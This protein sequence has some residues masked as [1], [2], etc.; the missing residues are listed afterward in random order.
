[1]NGRLADKET[2]QCDRIIRWSIAGL[3]VANL[4]FL[5]NKI[6]IPRWIAKYRTSNQMALT[7]RALDHWKS[8][9]SEYPPTLGAMMTDQQ[10]RRARP[11][12]H[13][14]S[15]NRFEY[16]RVDPNSYFLRSFGSDGSPASTSDDHDDIVRS[17]SNLIIGGLQFQSLRQFE[18][19]AKSSIAST[20]FTTWP[21]AATD[22]LWSPDGSWLARIV[23]N[24]DKGERRL[25]IISQDRS[26]LLTSPHDRVEEFMWSPHRE[27]CL[28]FSATGSDIHGDG[29]F[30]WCP[31]M[32]ADEQNRGLINLLPTFATNESKSGGSATIAGDTNLVAKFATNQN[33]NK[34]LR[35]IIA[36]LQPTERSLGGIDTLNLL[37]QTEK[38]PLF[39]IL[40]VPEVDFFSDNRSKKFLSAKNLW[41]CRFQSGNCTHI[42]KNRRLLDSLRVEFKLA[43]DPSTTFRGRPT[44]AQVVWNQLPVRGPAQKLLERWLA[45]AAN[46]AVGALQAYVMFYTV[47]LQD[48]VGTSSLGKQDGNIQAKL[49]NWSQQIVDRM[50][51]SIDTPRYLQVLLSGRDR[52]ALKYLGNSSQHLFEILDANYELNNPEGSP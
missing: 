15:G 46:P 16:I 1:M 9:H 31:T 6:P 43:L 44:T 50:T 34:N 12:L 41:T 51:G 48:D 22:G 35:W 3:V 33:H 45:A 40:A 18:K 8:I 19:P 32:S 21:P 27:P 14:A 23:T 17:S 7:M 38:E 4:L 52:P 29:V 47:I 49:A 13:D 28:I 24:M 37:P 2:N 11:P 39:H 26:R 25:L 20:E 36:L 10:I 5:G 42:T 30:R